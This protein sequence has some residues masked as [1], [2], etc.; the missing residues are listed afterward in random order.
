MTP[1]SGTHRLAGCSMGIN[2]EV[3]KLPSDISCTSNH[4]E[5]TKQSRNL[6]LL[7]SVYCRTVSKAARWLKVALE[8][9]VTLCLGKEQS[10]NCSILVPKK[11]LS[12]QR[13]P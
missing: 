9:C 12:A 8:L 1:G 10:Q 6:G 7:V 3:E 11:K 2:L 4:R 5:A 13:K